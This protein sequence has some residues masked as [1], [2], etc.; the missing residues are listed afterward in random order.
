MP[1]RKSR[2]KRNQ[3]LRPG[4]APFAWFHLSARGRESLSASIALGESATGLFH[5]P[6]YGGEGTRAAFAPTPR[7]GYSQAA[8]HRRRSRLHE[9]VILLKR[10]CPSA[11]ACWRGTIR[12]R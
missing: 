4:G 11:P 2:K 8:F 5:A 12:V 7:W 9:Q 6:E 1:N 10:G 3:L